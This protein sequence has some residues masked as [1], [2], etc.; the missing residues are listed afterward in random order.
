M[1]KFQ[2]ILLLVVAL[3]SGY[4]LGS[5]QP[6]TISS[7]GL[8]GDVSSN[9]LS[10]FGGSSA[11]LGEVKNALDTKFISWKATS[12]MP[13]TKDLEYGMIKG[14]VEAYN[15]PY[16]MFFPPAESKTF[17]E[18]VQGSFGGVG[19]QVGDK[20]GNA[21]VIAPLKD[22]PSQKAG[23]KSGD[24]IV[25]VNGIDMLGKDSNI[26][27]SKIRGPIGEEVTITVKR[28]DIADL[29]DIK[30]KREEIQIPTIDTQIKNGVFVISLYSF[31]SD[32]VR[33]FADAMDKYNDSNT[34][35]L[36]IDLRGNPGGF[37][38][39][40]VEIASIFIDQGKVVVSE[41]QGKQ[42]TEIDMRSKGYNTMLKKSSVV[43]L[44]DGGSASASEILAGAL[45]DQGVAKVVGVKTFGKG[46]VQ[47]YLN[48]SDG[49][50]VKVTIAKWY[51]P[52]GVNISL[53]GILPDVEAKFDSEKFVK[54]KI[55]T[56]LN[57]A[58]EVVKAM[59]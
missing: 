32:S 37:L 45:K 20:D 59:K 14:Y 46:S 52:A 30:I 21:V 1:N 8:V 55:D 7:G 47:E 48:L 19:M 49:S 40:A 10:S 6:H 3:A 11:L 27:V 51:T 13:T 39:S 50:A 35:K 18:N 24:T 25:K 12:T 26:V 17:T 28:A 4:G 57:K 34:N 36:V 41:K 29:I 54:Y 38:E 2:I 16:T 53:A 42:E 5:S 9:M 56:Q 22:S 15:D 43:V 23:I 44:V 31:N 58:I 33:L